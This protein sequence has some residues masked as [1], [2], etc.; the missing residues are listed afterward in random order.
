MADRSRGRRGTSSIR[1]RSCSAPTRWRSIGCCST[2]STTSAKAKGAISIWDRP[3]S[4]K[5][6][7]GRARDADPNVNIIIREPGHVEYAGRLGLGVHDRA[8]I[9]V[10]E[11]T[12]WGRGGGLMI[13]ALLL[14]AAPVLYLAPAR[15]HRP[16]AARGRNR[17]LC[18]PAGV[19]TPGALPGSTRRRAD[20][21]RNGR[22]NVL[23]TLG[24]A[25]TGRRGAPTQRPWIYANGW[26]FLR[27]PADRYWFEAPAG[28]G[29]S[30]RGRGIRLRGRHRARGRPADLPDA[31]RALALPR[32]GPAPG[33]RP[34]RT[35]RWWTTARRRR[36][37]S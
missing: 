3:G 12:V 21:E 14:A 19:V 36:P 26:R 6:D 33:L 22:P 27:R 29:G 7:D 17:P 9:R 1:G 25:G 32:P 18:A 13:D 15:R 4:L 24:L 35:S 16:G 2:S 11:I 31:G 30:R 8:L 20:S 28:P 5:I 37:R 34:S 23:K 10:E